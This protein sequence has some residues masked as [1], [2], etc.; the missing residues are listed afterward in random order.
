MDAQ[1]IYNK[2]ISDFNFILKSC[3]G[4][5]EQN[6]FTLKTF[7]RVENTSHVCQVVWLY[8]WHIL[9]LGMSLSHFSIIC[10]V[11]DFN[12]PIFRN[13]RR[14]RTSTQF[15]CTVWDCIVLLKGIFFEIYHVTLHYELMTWRSS[16]HAEH[17]VIPII[18]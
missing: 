13:V 4:K 12:L 17:I 7:I 5:E 18:S 9:V 6:I 14:D 11:I 2:Y 10:V 16:N 15:S 8:F 1:Q 3:C